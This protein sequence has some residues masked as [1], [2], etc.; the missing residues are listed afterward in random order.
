MHHFS[1][2]FKHITS[3]EETMQMANAHMTLNVIVLVLQVV[4]LSFR[5]HAKG[6]HYWRHGWIL[7]LVSV[8]LLAISSWLG[9][10][11]VYTHKMGVSIKRDEWFLLYPLSF[12]CVLSVCISYLIQDE[13]ALNLFYPSILLLPL[14]V[15]LSGIQHFEKL[16]SFLT[17]PRPGPPELHLKSYLTE[18]YSL[19]AF[20]W[21]ATRR[22][23]TDLRVDGARGM[24]RDGGRERNERINAIS[25]GG[26]IHTGVHKVMKEAYVNKRRIG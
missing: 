16:I 12:T 2:F 24:R 4:N 23:D 25:L 6:N 20:S 26:K 1:R 18:L 9:S 5:G 22:V 14:F 21:A 15:S 17:V 8:V 13:K 7:S 3:D 11:L 10:T 19:S